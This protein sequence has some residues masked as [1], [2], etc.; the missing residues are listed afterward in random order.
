MNAELWAIAE[1]VANGMLL[2]VATAGKPGLV[3]IDSNGSHDDMSALTFMRGSAALLPCIYECIETG[4]AFKGTPEE[5][6]NTT[7]RKSVV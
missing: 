2:E 7:D 6:F 1:A 4:Y 3:C 5:L